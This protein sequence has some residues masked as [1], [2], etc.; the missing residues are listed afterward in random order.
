M[1]TELDDPRVEARLADLDR[2]LRSLEATVRPSPGARARMASSP[3]PVVARQSVRPIQA[4]RPESVRPPAAS[5]AGDHSVSDL[6]G[7]RV[8]AWAG[9]VATLTGIVLFLAL[10]ISRG[11]IGIEARVALASIGSGLLMGAGVWLHGKRGRTEASVVMVGVATAGLFATIVVASHIYG[12][13]SPLAGVTASLFVGVLATAL[14]IR[15]AGHAIAAVGL[16][17][18]LLSPILVGAPSDGPTIAVLAGAAA[19]AIWTVLWQRWNWLG[20]AAVLIC[21]AQWGRWILEDQPVG[22]EILVLC[23]FGLVG[24]AGGLGRPGDSSDKRLRVSSA[25]LL[26]LSALVVGIVGAVSLRDTAAGHGAA[27]WLAALATVHIVLG[28]CRARPLAIAVPMR[29]LLLVLGVTLADV[30]IAL[31]TSGIILTLVWSA[32][33]VACACLSRRALERPSDYVLVE[34]AVGA[35]IALTLVLAVLAA[36]PTQLAGQPARLPELLAIAM[37]AAS[38]LGSGYITAPRARWL[39]DALSALGFV[40]IAYLTAQALSG[41]TLAAAWALEALALLRLAARTDSQPARYASA[42]FMTLAVTHTLFLEAPPTALLTGAPSLAAAAKAL[43]AI[44]LALLVASR[45][46]HGARRWLIAGGLMTLL[47]LASIAIATAFQ[48][49][50]G[51]ADI[52]LLDLSIR[53]QGQVLLSGFWSLVGVTGLIIG[54]QRNSSAIRNGALALLLATI[55]KVFLYDLSTLTSI[56]RVISFIALGLLLLAGAFAYQRL[57]PPPLPDMRRVHRSQR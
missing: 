45:V 34:L 1:A 17:G 56:Y 37:L 2:R 46:H 31:T 35:H 22:L 52:A 36:P 15:W 5:R 4:G 14:A 41:S 38:C 26:T 20:L 57:R 39:A 50:T 28:L 24:L 51:S 10:A 16:I 49:T 53:Q 7:G 8:L 23:W 13:I 48:P 25:T 6:L 32:A 43:G 29:R 42:A 55:A 33:A 18:A 40:A 27:M 54:L 12:V 44:T 47:D 30:A 19:C 9:G 3:P 11:W 21:A